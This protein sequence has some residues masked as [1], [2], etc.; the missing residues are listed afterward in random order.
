MVVFSSRHMEVV[1][2]F[3]S[4]R[5]LVPVLRLFCPRADSPEWVPICRCSL[6]SD[7]KYNIPLSPPFALPRPVVI[8]ALLAALLARGTH[9]RNGIPREY[10]RSDGGMSS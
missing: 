8:F 6:T 5:H 1:R 10:P 4:L 2:N 7:S 3:F 9:T